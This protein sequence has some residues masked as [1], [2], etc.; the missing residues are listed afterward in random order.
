MTNKGFTISEKLLQYVDT[1]KEIFFSDREERL[2]Q[3]KKQAC[4]LLKTIGIPDKKNEQYKYA[5]V[6]SILK[7]HLH[8]KIPHTA[9]SL[10]LD[11]HFRCNVPGLTEQNLIMFNGIYHKEQSPLIELPNGIVMGSLHAAKKKYPEIVNRYL[12]RTKK[13]N[14]DGLLAANTIMGKE[15][16]FIYVPKGTAMQDPVQII[17]IMLAEED[18]N[19]YFRHLIILEEQSQADIIN[20][21]HTLSLHK[22]M[23]NCLTEIFIGDGANLSFTNLQN[24][25]VHAAHFTHTFVDQKADSNALFH[26][27]SLNGGFIRNNIEAEMNGSYA[28]F[29]TEGLSIAAKEQYFDNY[30]VVKHNKPHCSSEQL[31][32]SILEENAQVTFTGKILVTQEAQKTNAFQTNKSLLLSNHAKANS[33]PQLEIYADDVKCSHGATVGKIDREALFYLKS[34]GIGEPEARHMLM[35][36]FADEVIKEIKSEKLRER[37]SDITE[38]RL[39]GELSQCQCCALNCQ[40]KQVL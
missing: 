31:Y 25:H 13:N 18:T 15:G 4:E 37:I 26:Y 6:L 24:E 27:V 9:P 5:D 36:A 29:K 10:N 32:K 20:C 22:F 30:V 3:E 11:D 38:T 23:S 35:F 34:R 16:I 1:N 7:K 8:G 33:K 19:A 21:S 28:N 40:Q 12:G 39:R 14:N 17:S 2:L